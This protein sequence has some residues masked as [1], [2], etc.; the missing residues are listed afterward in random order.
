M[1][2]ILSFTYPTFP[3]WSAFSCVVSLFYATIN[4]FEHA[5]ALFRHLKRELREISG[6][7][8]QFKPAFDLTDIG[9]DKPF[10]PFSFRFCC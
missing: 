8:G 3:M 4:S 7:E 1:G 2:K 6:L 10:E 9:L 5:M